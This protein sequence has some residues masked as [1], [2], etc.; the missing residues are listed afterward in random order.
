M[1]ESVQENERKSMAV[2]RVRERVN[3]RGR[4]RGWVNKVY[5][6]QTLPTFLCFRKKKQRK[7]DC[8]VLLP[9]VGF[10]SIFVST[11]FYFKIYF[12]A[13][14]FTS[15]IHTPTQ[16]AIHFVNRLLT[17]LTDSHRAHRRQNDN[18]QY[19]FIYEQTLRAYR[20]YTYTLSTYIYICWFF[21]CCLQHRCNTV[22]LTLESVLCVVSC[23]A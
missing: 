19:L 12:S 3:E 18:E 2:D 9:F 6:F 4:E 20:A 5:F 11:G 15:L 14:R 7:N 22:F 21:L 23:I 8:C 13:F 10:A 16:S 17:F 1:E